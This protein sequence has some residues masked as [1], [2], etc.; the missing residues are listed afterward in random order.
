M[1][2]FDEWLFWRGCWAPTEKIRKWTDTMDIRY[3]D[4]EGVYVGDL[5]RGVYNG[6]LGE[7]IDNRGGCEGAY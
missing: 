6:N 4:C 7:G 1:N 2:R 5:G 3:K